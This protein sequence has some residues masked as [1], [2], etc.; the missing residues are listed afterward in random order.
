LIL[1][2]PC[3]SA[4]RQAHTIQFAPLSETC[5]GT[6][7][8]LSATGRPT[9]T[10]GTATLTL[11]QSSTPVA[12]GPNQFDVTS[13]LSFTAGTCSQTINLTGTTT[14]TYL[15]LLSPLA[16]RQPSFQ[17]DPTSDGNSF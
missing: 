7:P 16:A 12:S 1:G 13:F 8:L 14:G 3:A 6:L 9:T 10:T 11:A 5:T 17:A 2:G 4:S 15:S